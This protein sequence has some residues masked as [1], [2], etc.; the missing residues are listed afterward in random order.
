M[1]K[2]LLILSLFSL[3][4]ISVAE[5]LNSGREN[6]SL[7]KQENIQKL[8]SLVFNQDQLNSLKAIFSTAIGQSSSKDQ[9]I[10]LN[11]MI[12]RMS[13]KFLSADTI[14][15]F[16]EIYSKHFSDDEIQDIVNFYDSKTGKKV[17][18]IMP[19]I[20]AES[21]KIGFKISQEVM[22]EFMATETKKVVGTCQ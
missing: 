10:Q 11:K 9:D 8:V 17:I 21:S 12:N 19:E 16:S 1:K 22:T 18:N 6:N 3:N 4:I 7:T 14:K 5:V 15:E 13:E 2:L 20:S